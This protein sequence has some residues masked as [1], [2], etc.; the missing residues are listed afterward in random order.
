MRRSL[1]L[2]KLRKTIIIYEVLLTE[3]PK[4][5]AKMH[6]FV[7]ICLAC[8]NIYVVSVSHGL[9]LHICF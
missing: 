6:L 8:Q 2:H 4:R 5:D 9:T 1:L 7:I 3:I